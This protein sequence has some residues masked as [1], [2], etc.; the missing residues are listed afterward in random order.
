VAVVY[1]RG[2]GFSREF[3]VGPDVCFSQY[4]T[5]KSSETGDFEGPLTAKS[6]RSV[7]PD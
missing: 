7:E 4:R 3:G 1:K 2:S 5:F 6:G